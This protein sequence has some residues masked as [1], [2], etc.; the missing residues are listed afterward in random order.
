MKLFIYRMCEKNATNR[1]QNTTPNGV[2]TI[3]PCKLFN[4]ILLFTNCYLQL[5]NS[6]VQLTLALFT[7]NKYTTTNRM[8]NT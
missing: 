1:K 4:Y 8:D 5:V 2:R 7:N 6:G 3:N